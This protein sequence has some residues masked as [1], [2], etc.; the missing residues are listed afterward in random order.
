MTDETGVATLEVW[1]WK[2][3]EKVTLDLAPLS[4]REKGRKM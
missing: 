2:V 3:K 1:L 4:S